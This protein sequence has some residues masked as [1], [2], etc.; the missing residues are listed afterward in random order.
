MACSGISDR[1]TIP[2]GGAPRYAEM[3]SASR[4]PV[5]EGTVCC[6]VVKPVTSIRSIIQPALTTFYGLSV[7]VHHR[8]VHV[9]INLHAAFAM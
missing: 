7:D 4:L 9:Q 2:T 6:A 5:H 3:E 8:I 1:P